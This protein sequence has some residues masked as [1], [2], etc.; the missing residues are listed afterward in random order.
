MAEA[1]RERELIAYALEELHSHL[2]KI[3]L[4]LDVDLA[5]DGAMATGSF[6]VKAAGDGVVQLRGADTSAVLC[7][8]YT[9]L[10]TAGWRFEITGPVAPLVPDAAAIRS[11]DIDLQPA[12]ARRG[13]RQH[14]N[15]P[16]DISSYPVEE[17]TEYVRNLARMRFTH[18]SFH[19]Y[20][21]QWIAGPQAGQDMP[22]GSFFY[23]IRHDLPDHPLLR[24]SI[25]NDQTFC[26]PAIEP[27]M[28]DRD[29]R[30]DR[31]VAWLR[32]VIGE[33]KRVG[34]YVQFSFEPRDQSDEIAPAVATCRRV[35]ELYPEIDTLE[36]ITNE[37]G[38][39]ED[40]EPT[41][42]E[43][44]LAR[45]YPAVEI[46]T[47]ELGAVWERPREGIATVFAEMGHCIRAAE[48]FRPEAEAHGVDLTVGVYFVSEEAH[49]A[50]L[51]LARQRLPEDVG[52]A[53][54][55]GHGSG[56]VASYLEAAG[57]LPARRQQTVVYTWIEFDGLEFVQQNG[58]PGIHR[59]LGNLQRDMAPEAMP[60]VAFNHWRT[61]EN[62]LTV[63]Y[64]A[65]ACLY[66]AREPGEFYQA[67]AAALGVGAPVGFAEALTALGEADWMATN[68][69]PNVGF[70][71]VGCWRRKG[72][73]PL[74]Y[75]GHWSREKLAEAGFVYQRVHELLDRCAAAT[76]SP[77]A[78]D[79]LEFL[80]NRIRCT[81]VYLR[82]MAKG[83]EMQQFA[84]LKPGNLSAAQRTEVV[85][86]CNEALAL[87]EQYLQLHAERLDDRGCE[88]TLIS[89]YYTAP[90][91]LKAIREDFGGIA[92][93][94][95]ASA[96]GLEPPPSP[97]AFD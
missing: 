71:Y 62:R 3:D 28:D 33:C 43:A 41:A 44:V 2:G 14:L 23:G 97:I 37:A 22:A 74:G 13:V 30:S 77:S 17:A 81:I 73:D 61:A 86:I 8:V 12:V 93:D 84:D 78:R 10:E 38:A 80:D 72:E 31:A 82:A 21:G 55:P 19:S 87:M 15:F 60:T 50:I 6:S 96:R 58:V 94:V 85:R 34:L 66:G 45:M 51:H 42:I 29:E 70:C 26:I 9:L 5:V 35:L 56:R 88:G 4:P 24:R 92:S 18:I 46:D 32:Q 11:V 40:C 65:E 49:P 63:R 90:A 89:A 7:A 20:P 67:Y 75:F 79:Y 54:L 59:L 47:P 16:M 69:L 95:G 76:A 48:A 1:G 52:F 64:A 36:M 27:F 68:D 83:C 91:V 53:I 25:R 57:E 39:G